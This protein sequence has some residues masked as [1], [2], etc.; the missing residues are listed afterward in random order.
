MAQPPTVNTVPI[1]HEERLGKK[2]LRSVTYVPRVSLLDRDNAVTSKDTYV[3]HD[4]L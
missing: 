4:S 2:V 3:S 1:V